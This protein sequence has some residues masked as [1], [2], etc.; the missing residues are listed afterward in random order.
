MK[1]VVQV[2]AIGAQRETCSI[3]TLLLALAI[4]DT[5]IPSRHKT[6]IRRT[7]QVTGGIEVQCSNP[8]R[9]KSFA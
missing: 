5:F 7:I 9:T 8:I 4:T 1:A 3:C 6:L 2:L